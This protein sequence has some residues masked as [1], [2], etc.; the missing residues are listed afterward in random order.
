[1][2][3][4]KR[5]L[6]I[7]VIALSIT[8]CTKQG[9]NPTLATFNG[10]EIDQNS[11]IT[12]YLYSTIYKPDVMPTEE[13]LIKI[14]TDKALE[15]MTIKAAH[16]NGFENDTTYQKACIHS[17]RKVL[18]QNYVQQYMITKVITDSLLLKFYNEINTQYRLR[19]IM[20]PFEDD[21]TASFLKLQEDSINFVYRQLRAGKNFEDMAKKYS[22]EVNSK[23]K[24]G[25]LGFVVGESIGDETLRTVMDTL[26]QFTYSKPFKGY[27]GFYI[28]YKGEERQV[29]APPFEE[30]K[31]KIWETIFR[32][33]RHQI[34]E[35]VD[36]QFD[37]L[38]KKYNYKVDQNLRSQIR[39]KAGGSRKENASE[40]LNFKALNAVD[41]KKSVARYDGG[42]IIIFELFENSKKA[43]QNMGEFDE[44]L[45]AVAKRHLYTLEA[46]SIGFDQ[47]DEIKQQLTDMRESIMKSVYYQQ[48]VRDRAAAI[49]DSVATALMMEK[50]PLSKQQQQ[51]KY[52]D[53]EKEIRAEF[54]QQ[55]KE[56]YR[57]T[58]LES[59]FSQAL[60]EAERRK[61]I[62]NTERANQK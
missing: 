22:Q 37:K 8:G 62:Q 3:I 13:N 26:T 21:A 30:V 40:I 35:L 42:E 48:K 29:T 60:T 34:Q 36:T 47:V 41:Q 7:A 32:T 31:P 38:I 12:H 43:P 19:Y 54:E 39:L 20:R 49:T 4:F 11:Y 59:N 5:S 61:E 18:Y 23:D 1:M 46:K 45:S 14:V 15:K 58:L 52:F 28:A 25:N 44:M 27:S 10:G 51:K 33:R 53:T 9:E 24:G 17:E 56:Q 16:D 6:F 55:L 50:K 57:F 2:P